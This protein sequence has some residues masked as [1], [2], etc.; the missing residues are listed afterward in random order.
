MSSDIIEYMPNLKQLT[1][2]QID[3][4]VIFFTIGN[5]INTVD[6][7]YEGT[8]KFFIDGLS[9]FLFRVIKLPIEVLLVT[10]KFL[11]AGIG[12]TLLEFLGLYKPVLAPIIIFMLIVDMIKVHKYNKNI[13]NEDDINKI[14][15]IKNALDFL[16]KYGNITYFAGFI[17]IIYNLQDNTKIISVFE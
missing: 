15:R 16:N 14:N 4:L 12:F 7:K 9:Y 11:E 1:L 2:N 6:Y 13:Q 17:K 10:K 5:D 3:K 8:L